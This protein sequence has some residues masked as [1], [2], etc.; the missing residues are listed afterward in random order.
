[1]NKFL[2][3]KSFISPFKRPKLNF[4]FGDIKIG[5]PYFL[6]RKWVKSDKKGQRKYVPKKF[7]FDF[8]SLGWKTKFGE[9][10]FEW[11]PLIS[12][13][14]FNKQFVVSI[15]APHQY[16]Y[17]EA[18]LAYELDTDKSKTKKE[19]IKYLIEN[20]PMTWKVT[21]NGVGESVNYYTKILKEKY[22][23][24]SKDELREKILNKILN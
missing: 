12:F 4:Y 23:P 7:G 1:M 24:L 2:Y 11:R 20:Y 18:W 10:R 16:H 3:L 8:V 22:K 14:A 6:P 5:T 9:Y 19:R 13:V 17:W 15:E 21:K